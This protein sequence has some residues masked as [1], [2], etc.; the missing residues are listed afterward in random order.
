MQP[1]KIIIRGR[2]WDSQLYKGRL[3]LFDLNGALRDL[4]W[5]S[6]VQSFT[7][8]SRCR[9]ALE[10]A[11]QRSDYLYGEKWEKFF[12]DQE[13]SD[14][15]K[16]KFDE[17]LK[18]NLT[19][20]TNELNQLDGNTTDTPFPYAHNDSLVYKDQLYATSQS[21]VFSQSVLEPTIT[22]GSAEKL[23]DA[24]VS[25]LD[26]S[27]DV[28]ALAAGDEGLFRA[29]T[30]QHYRQWTTLQTGPQSVWKHLC[31][32]CSYI[33]SSILAF[34]HDSDS[35]LVEFRSPKLDPNKTD[36]VIA[37][38]FWNSKSI[39]TVEGER[40]FGQ[41][42]RGGFV[43]GSKNR[44]CMAKDGILHVTQYATTTPRRRSVAKEIRSIQLAPWKGSPVSGDNAVFGAILE[45]DHCLV[46]VRS[47]NV[48]D[49]LQGEPTN[50]R[51]FPRSKYYTNQLHII[52]DD[53]I[54]ILSFNHD[55]FV[56]QKGKAFGEPQIE[57]WLPKR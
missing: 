46:I 48:I 3:Y 53:R 52:Y 49:T 31:N 12:K 33:S 9:L 30:A 35:G 56:N 50:W 15:L 36:D 51:V 24:P 32:D 26:I 1:V 6:L 23:W 44:M 42:T 29:P 22:P 55:Y 47:D 38:E 28:L 11:F 4:D 5:N 2:F 8:P 19:V 41:N 34:G 21:G 14:L 37:Q 45:L 39:G 54:E 57:R 40:I 25:A 18:Q 16:S 17:L 20:D 13:I 7:M 27:H 43:W 10:C